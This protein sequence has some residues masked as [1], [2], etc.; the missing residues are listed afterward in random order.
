[1]AGDY[2]WY[3]RE[4]MG[5]QWLIPNKYAGI[6]MECLRNTTKHSIRITDLVTE[7]RT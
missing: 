2:E 4:S 6:R 1:M 7:I 5:L 3:I